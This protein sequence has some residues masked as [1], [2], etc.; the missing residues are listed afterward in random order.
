MNIR[1]TQIEDKSAGKVVLRVEGALAGEA[2]ELVEKMCQKLREKA[3]AKVVVDLS[4]V[5]FVNEPG[6][7]VLRRLKKDRRIEFDGCKLFTERLIEAN[8][9]LEHQEK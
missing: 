2:A 5:S 1:I 7:T 4:E 8:I 3:E 6:A 9:P